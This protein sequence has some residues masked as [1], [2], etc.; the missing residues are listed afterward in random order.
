M[1]S[2]KI[3]QFYLLPFSL[4]LVKTCEIS[5]VC[6][7]RDHMYMPKCAKLYFFAVEE[8][9]IV[10]KLLNDASHFMH[11]SSIM[12]IIMEPPAGI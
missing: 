1:S 5:F 12:Q 7:V 9:Q 10:H 6:F 11:H 8:C 4:F 2:I 3:F